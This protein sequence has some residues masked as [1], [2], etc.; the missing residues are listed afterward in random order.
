MIKKSLS[1][2]L[3][4]GATGGLSASARAGKLPVAPSF[5]AGS[6]TVV[7]VGLELVTGRKTGKKTLIGE[8]V[9]KLDAPE[10][11]AGL[12]RYLEDIKL[13]RML[14][15]KILFSNR[16]HAR[17][18]GIDTSAARAMRG[19]R[20]VLIAAD[21][22]LV[23][24]GFGRDNTA[25]KTGKV[26]CIRDEIAAVAADTPG[27]AAAAIQRIQVTYEDLPVVT[28]LDEALAD[29]APVIHEK[30]PDNVPFRFDYLHGDIEHGIRE[31][32][33]IVEDT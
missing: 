21:I 10:K 6:K 32:D 12:T 20:A 23:P 4:G 22:E 31:S 29:G 7:E 24:F 14:Y 27:I 2:N 33:V 1:R 13:P 3:E 26:T 8:R 15:G 5:G 16:P 25:L 17:I 18:L 28:S 30:T 19:V 9:P 11:V